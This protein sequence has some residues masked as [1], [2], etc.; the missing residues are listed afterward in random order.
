MDVM[1]FIRTPDLIFHRLLPKY[2]I[3]VTLIVYNAIT[4]LVVL[5]LKRSFTIPE[6]L[7]NSPF[8]VEQFLVLLSA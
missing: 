3:S 5:Y 7:L 1:R 2:E 8:Y 6:H 4:I